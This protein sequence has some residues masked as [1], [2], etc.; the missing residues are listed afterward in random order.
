[1]FSTLV[2]LSLV[3]A[4]AEPPKLSEEAQKEL[5]KFEGKWKP[6]KIVVNDKEEMPPDAD[7]L[8]EFK[9]RKVLIADNELFEINTLDPSTNPKIIDLKALTSMGEITK[10]TV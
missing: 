4:A 8:L 1:M 3:V 2:S 9:G 7:M 5:K 10:D 6:E